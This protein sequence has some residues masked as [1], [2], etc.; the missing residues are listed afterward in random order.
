MA[1]AQVH[2]LADYRE[3]CKH[4]M[5]KL[6]CSWCKKKSKANP[7]LHDGD[8]G[9]HLDLDRSPIPSGFIQAKFDSTCL[10][11][12]GDIEMGDLIGSRH[13]EWICAACCDEEDAMSEA[14]THHP[15]NPNHRGA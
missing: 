7:W 9:H 4:D 1:N 2:K 5:P 14:K 13:N 10:G 8:G 15:S 3:Q 12:G 11:C 6:L